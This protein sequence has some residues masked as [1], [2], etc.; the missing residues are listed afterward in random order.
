MLEVHCPCHN[1]SSMFEYNINNWEALN[2]FWTTIFATIDVLTDYYTFFMVLFFDKHVLFYEKVGVGLIFVCFTLCNLRSAHFASTKNVWYRLL[3]FFGFGVLIEYISL[4]PTYQDT[5]HF[6]HIVDIDLYLEIIPSGGMYINL[7]IWYLLDGFE[8]TLISKLLRTIPAFISLF[9]I[10][11]SCQIHFLSHL[12]SNLLSKICFGLSIATDTVLRIATFL[13]FLITIGVGPLYIKILAIL[14][15]ALNICFK[16]LYFMKF[17]DSICQRIVSIIT[18][19][20]T[21]FPVISQLHKQKNKKSWLY[22]LESLGQDISLIYFMSQFCLVGMIPK[23]NF[24]TAG[25][26]PPTADR[27]PPTAEEI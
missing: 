17:E 24:P 5:M 8:H 14:F 4:D 7:A 25:R 23:M 1:L 15:F 13:N 12:D 26:R 16:T 18:A 21:I 9:T 11:Y 27:R 22:P 20:F 2:V 3:Y 19:N 6:K 10:S